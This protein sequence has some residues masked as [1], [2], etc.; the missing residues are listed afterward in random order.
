MQFNRFGLPLI[1]AGQFLQAIVKGDEVARTLGGKHGG[2][3]NGYALS[4]GA[5]FAREFLACVVHQNLTHVVSGD[6]DEVR[7]AFVFT[8]FLLRKPHPGFVDQSRW[9]QRVA[10]TLIAHVLACQIA[11]LGFH[12]RHQCIQSRLIALLPLTEQVRDF[13]LWARSHFNY[14]CTISGGEFIDPALE[15]YSSDD[16]GNVR[17]RTAAMRHFPCRECT[18]KLLK[19]GLIVAIAAIGVAPAA[20][21]VGEKAPAFELKSVDGKIVKLADVVAKGPLA[22]IVLRGFPGYQCPFCQ[23]QVMDFIQKADA[24]AEAGMQV[25]FVYPGPPDQT[26]AKAGEFMQNKQLPAHF[27]MLLD[28]GYEFTKSYG[29]RWEGKGETAYPATFLIDKNGVVIFEKIAKMHGGR[30]SATEIVELLPK[31]KTATQ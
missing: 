4:S 14:S 17:N 31:K 26:A 1:E 27:I 30:S 6:G 10:C 21:G 9:L 25:V 22:L 7:A 24:F 16:C 12:H 28:P 20:P 15:K 18:L 8:A 2:I 11:Q 3:I 23:R 29:L 13:V 19:L 5:A